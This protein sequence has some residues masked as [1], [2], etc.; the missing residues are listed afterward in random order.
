[1]MA[2]TVSMACMR[3]VQYYTAIVSSSRTRRRWETSGTEPS[4]LSP[5]QRV[6]LYLGSGSVCTLQDCAQEPNA[7]AYD[8]CLKP[9][10]RNSST[11]T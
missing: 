6:G 4:T 5:H 11:S 8:T 10:Q 9:S 1:M 2:A 7:K 3:R